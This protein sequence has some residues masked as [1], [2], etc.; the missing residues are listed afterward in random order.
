LC[1]KDPRKGNAVENYRPI[2]CVPLIWKPMTGLIA[3]HMYDYLERENIL[4][5]E[6]IGCKQKNRGTKDYF[7]IDI[8]IPEGLQEKAH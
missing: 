2:T 6:A 1:Q 5:D 4:P 7:L 8:T 3:A